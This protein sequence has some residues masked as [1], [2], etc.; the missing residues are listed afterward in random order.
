MLLAPNRTSMYITAGKIASFILQKK[1]EQILCV[2]KIEK[3]SSNIESSLDHLKLLARKIL[4]FFVIFNYKELVTE[5]N[6]DF[7][8]ALESNLGEEENE[9]KLISRVINVDLKNIISGEYSKTIDHFLK[10][11]IATEQILNE[12]AKQDNPIKEGDN[13]MIEVSK[14]KIENKKLEVKESSENI[15]EIISLDSLKITYNKILD[16]NFI[17][18]EKNYFDLYQTY[19]YKTCE[20]C[21]Q[22]ATKVDHIVCLICGATICQKCCPNKSPKKIGNLSAHSTVH[23]GG[24]SIF[25]N[26]M[27]STHMIYETPRLFHFNGIYTDKV[28]YSFM[29]LRKEMG[30]S[31]FDINLEE[32]VFDNE[33]LNN[34][35]SDILSHKLSDLIVQQNMKLGKFITP[36]AL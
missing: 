18:L 14:E 32:L 31:V 10:E 33:V 22:K 1:L 34:L 7:S 17:P 23:H 12:S 21:N 3:T 27:E 11:L 36:Q 9:L 4:C 6:K 19:L 2:L 25:I 20:L 15:Q 28:G 5:Q 29:E 8:Q 30:G 35:K 13:E 26:I 16:F 24:M